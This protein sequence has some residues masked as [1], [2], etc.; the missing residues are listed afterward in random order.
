MRGRL[1]RIVQR[2]PAGHRRTRILGHKTFLLAFVTND[3]ADGIV[4]TAGYKIQKR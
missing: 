3:L 4:P 2:V 1:L